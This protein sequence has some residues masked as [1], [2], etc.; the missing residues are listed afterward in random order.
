MGESADFALMDR[1]RPPASS[2]FRGCQGVKG[3]EPFE[4]IFEADVQDFSLGMAELRRISDEAWASASPLSFA[5]L[6]VCLEVCLQINNDW[7]ALDRVWM[8]LLVEPGTVVVVKDRPKNA[9]FVLSV[10]EWGCI[11]WPMHQYHIGGTLYF[12]FENGRASRVA[13]EV[14]AVTR[15]GDMRVVQTQPAWFAKY[16]SANP[17]TSNR[18]MLLQGEVP[19]ISL[20]SHAARFAFRQLT[21]PRLKMLLRDLIPDFATPFPQ[22]EHEL[23]VALLRKVVPGI[24][25]DDIKSRMAFRGKVL[26]ATEQKSELLSEEALKL[27]KSLIGDDEYESRFEKPATKAQRVASSSFASAAPAGSGP[28]GQVASA[29][30]RPG[31]PADVSESAT[32]AKR[33]APPG[34]LL[35]L[36]GK[37]HDRWRVNMP[38]KPVPPKSH[39]RSFGGTT[40]VSSREALVAVLAWSWEQHQHMIGAVCPFALDEA[41]LCE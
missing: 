24:S 27:G 38:H 9:F 5:M 16:S 10:C 1:G 6:P 3:S 33:F 36:E 25:E 2:T 23:V 12:G 11:V 35:H 31:L 30:R 8:S 37:W 21:V 29:T 15:S 19:A 32:V 20:L 13:W 34:C 26:N 22:R 28:A 18:G 4:K 17:G 14:L 7:D 39:S 40:G 41:P